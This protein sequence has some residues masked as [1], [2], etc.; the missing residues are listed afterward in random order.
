MI[1]FNRHFVN[2]YESLLELYLQ[3]EFGDPTIARSIPAY[4]G[5]KYYPKQLEEAYMHMKRERYIKNFAV[6]GSK[7]IKPA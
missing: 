3:L 5:M 4:L 7:E 2:H 1:H 6:Y